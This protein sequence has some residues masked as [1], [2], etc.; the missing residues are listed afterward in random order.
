[1]Q[2]IGIRDLQT[3]P[4]KVLS[5]LK[6]SSES[7]LVTKNGKPTAL[8][9]PIDEDAYE[10][11]VLSNAPVFVKGVQQA[12]KEFAEGETVTLDEALDQP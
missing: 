5:E 7:V 2:T 8:L 1:M 4:G 6:A 11:F 9:T 3:N 10:E 12:E